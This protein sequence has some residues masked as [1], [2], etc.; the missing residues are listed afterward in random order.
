MGC[1]VLQLYKHRNVTNKKVMKICSVNLE[2]MF[3][4]TIFKVNIYNCLILFHEAIKISAELVVVT[5]VLSCL[6]YFTFQT[7]PCF[8]SCDC[9]TGVNL[10]IWIEEAGEGGD[11]DTM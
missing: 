3:F 10:N 8:L 4:P 11:T 2:I 6:I 7:G 5:E 1:A 9:P